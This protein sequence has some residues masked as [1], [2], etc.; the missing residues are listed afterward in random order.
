MSQRA[1]GLKWAFM[2]PV[3]TTLSEAFFLA[4]GGPSLPGKYE[5]FLKSWTEYKQGTG[6]EKNTIK[7]EIKIKNKPVQH[8]NQSRNIGWNQKLSHKYTLKHFSEATD[9]GIPAMRTSD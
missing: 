1:Q 7:M 2:S 3:T 8:I 5:T 9:I 4:G 6:K